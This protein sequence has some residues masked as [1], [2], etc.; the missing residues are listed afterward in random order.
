MHVLDH[1]RTRLTA[2]RGK[3]CHQQIN[4]P[5]RKPQRMLRRRESALATFRYGLEWPTDRGHP[6]GE[7]RRGLLNPDVMPGAKPGTALQRII[8]DQPQH[9]ARRRI[10]PAQSAMR[11]H[12][13]K[14][15]RKRQPSPDLVPSGSAGGSD[16]VMRCHEHPSR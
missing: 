6:V 15:R 8:P 1:Q 12:D 7:F 14:N 2:Q 10:R 3:I 16:P 4:K 9:R 11:I 13:G 5:M